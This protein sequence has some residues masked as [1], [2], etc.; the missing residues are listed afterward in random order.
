M[1]FVR[2]L[3]PLVVLLLPGCGELLDPAAAVVGG[4]KITVERITSIVDAY[5]GSREFK[6]VAG[7]GDPQEILRQYE[8]TRLSQLIRRAVLESRAED[9]DVEVTDD[10]VARRLDQIKADFPSEEAFQDAL[11][12]QGLTSDYLNELVYDS[13]LEEGLRA[14][15]TEGAGPTDEELVDFYQENLNDYRQTRAQHILVKS[16]K[17]AAALSTRLRAA[18]GNQVED[19]FAR[20]AKRYSTDTSN[21][22]KGGDL[23]YF[24]EGQFVPPFEQAAADLSIGEVSEP[25][26]TEFGF[27]VI[28]VTDRRVAPFEEVRADIEQQLGGQAEDEAWQKWVVDAYQDADIRVNPRYGELDLDT[29]QIVNPSA[30]DVPGADESQ[31]TPTPEPTTAPTP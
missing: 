30:E 20:L 7:Q 14:K 17:L 3:V 27:H 9:L 2:L 18:P 26:Q 23:G 4:D 24:S 15:V 16:R 12:E 11:A 5:E 31:A 13:L 28:R 19:L 25:V 8:Q 6:Q 21:A 29:Q 22:A 1:K 10:D